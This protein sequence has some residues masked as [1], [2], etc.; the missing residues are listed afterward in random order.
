MKTLSP[1][2]METLL[3]EFLNNNILKDMADKDK[4]EKKK[5]EEK[6]FFI[7]KWLRILND[8]IRKYLYELYELS[9]MFLFLMEGILAGT[10]ISHNEDLSFGVRLSWH[11]VIAMICILSGI[12]FISQWEKLAKFIRERKEYTKASAFVVILSSSLLFLV[13]LT[14]ALV[15][16]AVTFL[17]MASLTESMDAVIYCINVHGVLNIPEWFHAFE[18]NAAIA[19]TY[20]GTIFHYL[21][22]LFLILMAVQNIKKKPKTKDEK[23]PKS[24]PKT[25]PKS[26]PTKPTKPTKPQKDSSSKKPQGTRTRPSRP[27]NPK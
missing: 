14:A 25:P 6:V 20:L 26:N 11:I 5:E 4:K 27:T 16:P 18:G 2:Q 22:I 17:L 15:G 3:Q 9:T 7:F 10:V 12:S 19:S 13:M 8:N 21:G 1:D 23:S 24:G